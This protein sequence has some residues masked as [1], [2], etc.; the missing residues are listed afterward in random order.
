MVINVIIGNEDE[1]EVKQSMESSLAGAMH[2]NTNAPQDVVDTF[3]ES[4]RLCNPNS[5]SC[6]LHGSK[7]IALA[8]QQKRSV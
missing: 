7:S 5:T 4:Y 2:C 3:L 1:S 8:A 6:K